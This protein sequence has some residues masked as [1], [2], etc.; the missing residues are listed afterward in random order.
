L[1]NILFLARMDAN[2]EMQARARAAQMHQS[3]QLQ[4]QQ[5]QK[6]AEMEAMNEQRR[7]VVRSVLEPEALERLNRIGLVKPDKQR[8]LEELIL[9]N[10]QRG[11]IRQKIDEG[12]FVNLL[13]QIEKSESGGASR[14][15]GSKTGNIQFKRRAFEDDDSD[16][17]LDNLE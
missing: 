9:A 12:T 7:A 4:Q 8:K 10:V 15:D 6:R 5:E 2:E 1:R 16:I 3:E 14:P 13:Q 17:D 11:A